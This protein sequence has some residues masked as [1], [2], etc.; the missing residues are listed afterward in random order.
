MNKRTQEVARLEESIRQLESRIARYD[1]GQSNPAPQA[2]SA[3]RTDI[4]KALDA[5][6]QHYDTDQF[7]NA[8][9]RHFCGAP[10]LASSDADRAAIRALTTGTEPGASW[11]PE[12]P[13]TELLDL[14][15]EAGAF[16]T[17][18][19]IRLRKGRKKFAKAGGDPQALWIMP[20]A[21]GTAL[22]PSPIAGSSISKA[23]NTGG[24]LFEPT[25]ELFEDADIDLGDVLRSKGSR[26]L[27]SLIDHSVFSG[28]GDEAALHGGQV[29]I[30]VHG[31]VP[32]AEA[33]AGRTA[34]ASLKRDDFVR[35]IAAV[36]PG[37]LTRNPR[38]WI[39]AS[40]LA[41]LLI[42]RETT[43]EFLLTR[44]TGE[45]VI[46]GH[47]VTFT[48]GAPAVNEPAAK[49]AAFGCGQGYA[50]GIVNAVEIAVSTHTKFHTGARQVRLLVRARGE[51]IEPSAF[52]TLKLAVE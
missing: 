30:F 9:A 10:A 21:Q 39:H 14:A 12:E 28:T 43:G 49:V 36:S 50:V 33:S 17:L 44:E 48:I 5:R 1:A 18:N 13:S 45:W 34:I 7:W 42:V 26:A 47:P 19:V 41:P 38:W 20:T 16:Q 51:M 37:A 22:V 27:A 2:R 15:E 52:A 31:D 8:V 32:T 11:I 6:G 3:T 23:V 46:C 40:F 4:L 25:V 29:G 35:C 24:I